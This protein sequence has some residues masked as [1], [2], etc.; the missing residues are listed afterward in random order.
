LERDVQQ[1]AG[2]FS[3]LET[4]SQD[5]QSKGLHLRD[6]IS[7]VRAITQHARELWDL[8]DPTA[9]LLAFKLDRE[10]HDVTVAPSSLVNKFT[11]PDLDGFGDKASKRIVSFTSR[12]GVYFPT[13]EKAQPLAVLDYLKQVVTHAAIFR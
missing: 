7:L 3:V 10:D 11:W 8:S 4:L 6:G 13:V 9:V 5:A 1:F 12:P 2:C